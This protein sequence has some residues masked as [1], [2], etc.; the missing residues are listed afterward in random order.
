MKIRIINDRGTYYR[1]MTAIGPA[2]GGTR[3]DAAV[4]DDG[5]KAYEAMKRFPFTVDAQMVN[6]QDNPCSV[7]GRSLARKRASRG[8]EGRK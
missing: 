7:D 6:D 3:E 1:F 5:W 2:F 8:E 4:F